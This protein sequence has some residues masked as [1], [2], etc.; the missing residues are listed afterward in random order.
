MSLEE[1]LRLGYWLHMEV[2]ID[3]YLDIQLDDSYLAVRRHDE[4]VTRQRRG[5]DSDRM[6]RRAMANVL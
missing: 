6:E 4:G 3:V 1:G 2:L 5:S